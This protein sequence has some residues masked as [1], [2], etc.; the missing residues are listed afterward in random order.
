MYA[1]TR[2]FVDE[3]PYVEARRHRGL[4]RPEDLADL[5]AEGDLD[6]LLLAVALDREL[7]RLAG[8]VGADRHD[9]RDAVGDPL[10]LDLG[11]QVALLSA[12]RPRRVCPP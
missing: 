10:A 11:D 8:L 1:E 6:R 12:R 5:R 3:H 2:T 7:D 9:Q 4:S